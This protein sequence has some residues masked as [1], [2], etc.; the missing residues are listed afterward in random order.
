MKRKMMLLAI[1]A[2]L[3]VLASCSSGGGG[4]GFDIVKFLQNPLV[5]IIGAIIVAAYL[6][7]HQKK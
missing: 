3:L 1:L 6:W 4:G 7:K 5:M 2:A